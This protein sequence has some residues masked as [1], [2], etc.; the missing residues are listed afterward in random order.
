M[1]GNEEEAL[2]LNK[3]L[4]PLWDFCLQYTGIRAMHAAASILGLCTGVPS[5]PLLPLPAE[6]KEELEGILRALKLL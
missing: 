6:A 3:E 1:A 2:R 4:Q 5:K